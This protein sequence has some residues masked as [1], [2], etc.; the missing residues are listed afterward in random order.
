[1]FKRLLEFLTLRWL[2][3]AA[4]E[5][6]GEGDAKPVQPSPS[7]TPTPVTVLSRPRRSSR[8]SPRVWPCLALATISLAREWVP[9]NARCTLSHNAASELIVS[10][11]ETS[12]GFE[13]IARA[14]DRHARV[15]LRR[16]FGLSS[17]AQPGTVRGLHLGS[18][19]GRSQYT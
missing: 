4:I 1:M 14:A 3:V 8:W 2:A 15:S 16:I 11:E 10:P 19:L 18:S 13:T 17:T 12:L 5:A 6:D 9:T 7:L